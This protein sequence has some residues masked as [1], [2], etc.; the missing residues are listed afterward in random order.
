MMNDKRF[1]KAH[2][3]IIEG[4]RSVLADFPFI[5]FCTL[6]GSAASGR[7]T[8]SSDID[9]AVAGKEP[10]SLAVKNEV[11]LELSRALKRDIDL[12]DLQTVSGLILEQSLCQS[13][14]VINKNRPL[15]AGLL[16]RLWYFQADM[17]PYVRRILEQRAEKWLQ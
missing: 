5:E 10:L 16:K 2:L 15:Y 11:V 6:F 12:V 14:I 9:I 3:D 4:I 13:S 1:E 8:I 17:K 7:L